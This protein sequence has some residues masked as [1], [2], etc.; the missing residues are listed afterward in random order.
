MPVP[1]DVLGIG[2]DAVLELDVD[3]P[4]VEGLELLGIVAAFLADHVGEELHRFAGALQAE[5]TAGRMD[6]VE[7]RL[8]LHGVGVDRDIAP[9][10][11]GHARQHG[12]G[13]ID[14]LLLRPGVEL[15][16][17]PGLGHGAD[18]HG[19][20]PA[21]LGVGADEGIDADDAR[22]GRVVAAD[23]RQ[24]GGRRKMGRQGHGRLAGKEPGVG[25]DEDGLDAGVLHLPGPEVGRGLAVDELRAG[26]DVGGGAVGQAQALGQ[27]PGRHLADIEGPVARS[28]VDAGIAGHKNAQGG[29]A[30]FFLSRIGHDVLQMNDFSLDNSRAEFT[31]CP[32]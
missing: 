1:D 9:A 19:A 21:G 25:D 14:D 12:V 23:A 31:N 20:E 28:L 26:E 15:G 27:Q 10:P 3:D 32:G 6:V 4:V 5:E 8:H 22:L 17:K 18:D 2:V 7:G 13:E 16:M 11:E 30:A 24:R 29:Q